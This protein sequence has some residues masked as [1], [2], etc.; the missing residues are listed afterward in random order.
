MDESSQVIPET[1]DEDGDHIPSR[2]MTEEVFGKSVDNN[3][4]LE[5]TPSPAKRKTNPADDQKASSSY[6]SQQV[7]VSSE[8]T[9]TNDEDVEIII[10]DKKGQKDLFWF[11]SSFYYCVSTR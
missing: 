7:V 6:A 5:K 1:P 11:F 8:V 4:W 2:K 3:R 9:E 10:H